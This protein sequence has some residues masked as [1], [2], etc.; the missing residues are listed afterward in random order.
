MNVPGTFR[1]VAR[2]SRAHPWLLGIGFLLLVL[3]A[4]LDYGIDE[5]VRRFM[6]EGGNA[7][8]TGYGVRV[9]YLDIRPWTLTMHFRDL[10]FRQDAHPEKP[11]VVLPD[12]IFTVDWQGLVLGRLVADV[13]ILRP[14]IRID[15]VQLAAESRDEVALEERGWQRLLEL[16][17][18]RINSFRVIDGSLSYID[19]DSGREFALASIQA[20][21]R[22]I[23][24]VS[25]EGMRYPS[26]VRL[27]ARVFDDGEFRLA[28][29]ADFLRRP[30]AAVNG[31]VELSQLPLASLGPVVDDYRVSLE[32]G[33]VSAR[34]QIEVMPEAYI[35]NMQYVE[36]GELKADVS[37]G[38][39]T[40]ATRRAKETV[41]KAARVA[42][43][44]PALRLRMQTLRIRGE[45][46]YR[47]DT[48]PPYRLFMSDADIRISNLSNRAAQGVSRL[49]ARGSFM[50]SGATRARG[51]WRPG[52]K[53]PDFAVDVQS[54]NTQLKSLNSL[55]RAHG[56]LDVSDGV[57]AI[58]AQLVARDGKL[59]G[60]LKPLFRDIDVLSEED[61]GDSFF[62]KLYEVIAEKLARLL[63]NQ[64][65]DEV[66]TVANLSGDLSDPDVSGWQVFVNL[67][68][69][70]FVEAILPGFDRGRTEK[71]SR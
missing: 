11:V 13:R 20:E 65:R 27:E 53:Y 37:A 14:A 30:H 71:A 4:F 69:N 26:P 34:G 41:K 3:I 40:A 19:T 36:V 60:Y 16:I 21:A 59:N 9:P 66:A 35:A 33:L 43:T 56:R 48:D 24:H 32:G 58:Y 23:R 50:G 64:E 46:G 8:L 42:G 51:V 29:N 28:G 2:R 44:S 70:A 7:R 68:R 22:N 25:G 54:V 31:V 38:I 61:E 63:E 45:I 47:S 15:T 39:P 62:Q 17:P 5:P 55:L 67:L 6:E 18:L 57:V 1:R 12:A 49:D 10:E 52:A